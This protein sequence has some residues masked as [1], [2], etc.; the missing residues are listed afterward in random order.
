MRCRFA[1]LSYA[2]NAMLRELFWVKTKNFLYGQEV[3]WFPLDGMD[4]A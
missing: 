3:M 2:K 1:E 4:S